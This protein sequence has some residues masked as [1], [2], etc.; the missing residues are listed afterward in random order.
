V[1]VFSSGRI[2]ADASDLHSGDIT[3]IVLVAKGRTILQRVMS[4]SWRGDIPAG[5]PRWQESSR[6]F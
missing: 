3:L 2:E 5:H 6:S 1:T 4:M